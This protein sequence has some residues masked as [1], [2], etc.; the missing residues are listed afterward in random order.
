V[1]AD[2]GG[3]PVGQT[4]GTITALRPKWLPKQTYTYRLKL[5][6]RL[7]IGDQPPMVAFHLASEAEL[8][9]RELPE[10]SLQFSVRLVGPKFSGASGGA[11]G[12]FDRLAIELEA[13]FFFTLTAGRLAEVRGRAGASRF[14]TSILHTIAASLQ[15]RVRQSQV[16]L[17]GQQRKSTGRGLTK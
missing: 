2:A 1:V 12:Q 14:A 15:F 17:A 10:K 13:P 7:A 8:Q 9:L 4:L 6:S 11:D 3:V 5:E 16:F